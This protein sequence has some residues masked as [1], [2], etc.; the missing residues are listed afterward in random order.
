ML[1]LEGITIK[2]KKKTVLE[3]VDFYSAP[4]EIVGLLGANGSGKSTLLSVIA[5]AK[6]AFSGEL[7]LNDI[8]F[9]EN[10]DEYRSH[11]GYVPQE[12]PLI[13]E[14][15]A[16]DN[17]RIWSDVGK[18]DMR[19]L[20]GSAPLSILGVAEFADNKVNSLSGGMKK[21]LSI[22]ATLITKPK[23][24][25]MD[26]PFA[27]LDMVAKHDIMD[28]IVGYKNSGGTVII[29]SHEESVLDF[30]DRIYF[31]NSGMVK[32]I[33]RGNDFKYVDILRGKVNV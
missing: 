6:K 10:P 22:T 21:R 11:M 31:I 17:L 3:N 1:K 18:D 15:S 23:V 24:L 14:L 4:G 32:E 28:Y 29:A 13:A 19:T 20:I 8:K 5:G 26:E 30:C 2:Y 7:S 16:I 25:L 33:N 27:A 12:N 9:S